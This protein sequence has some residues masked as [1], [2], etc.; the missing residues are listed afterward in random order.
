MEALPLAIAEFRFSLSALET[1]VVPARNKGNMLRGAL[2]T[3]LQE[4][5]G[6]AYSALFAPAPPPDAP[7]L[8]NYESIPRPFVIRPPLDDKTRY[9]RGETLSFRLVLVGRAIESRHVF[10]DAFG[11]IAA[12]GIGLNRARCEL[13]SVTLVDSRNSAAANFRTVALRFLTPTLLVFDQQPV[14]QLEFHHLLRR[15]RDRLNALATFYGDGPL[16]MDF[17]GLA[18]RAQQIR[19]VDQTLKW[20]SESR[21]SSRTGQRHALEG[22]TGVATFT[23]ELAEFLPLLDA[24]AR[25]HVGKHCTWGHG[26]FEVEPLAVQA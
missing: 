11:V 16:A 4:A 21:R 8:S 7:A 10:Q 6:D 13:R 1:L 3:A 23:G 9:E 24:G 2:G 26:W 5:G 19:C 22:F 25:V 18:D 14:R 15:L 12:R 20:A 17:R